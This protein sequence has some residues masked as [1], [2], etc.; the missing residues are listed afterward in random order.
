MKNNKQKWVLAVLVAFEIALFSVT[1]RNFFSITNFFECIRL[2]VEIGLLALALTPVIVTGGIDLSVG[3]MMGLCAVC[4]GALWSDAHWPMPVAV[5]VTLLI[6]LAG[7]AINGLLISRLNVSALVVTLG[8]YSLFRG[9]AEAIT[10]GAKN[11]SGFPASFLFLGQGYLGGVVPAQTV[12][13]VVA[14]IGFWALLHRSVVGRGWYAIGHSAVAAKYAA[15]PV[16]RRVALA[17]VLSGFSAGMAA[18]IYI[19][20]LGQAR[21]DAGTGYEL[22]AITA[23]ILGGA[24]ILG[25]SGTITGTLLGLAA[26]VI[27]QNGLRLSAW[28]TELAG[29]LTGVLLI[30]TIALEQITNRRTGSEGEGTGSLSTHRKRWTVALAG[31]VLAVF[32]IF[33]GHNGAAGG[34]RITIGVMPKA[35]GDPYFI[36]CRKGAEEAARDLNIDLI[37]DGP[38]AL[39]AA[40]QNAVVQGWI[41]RH[42]DAISVAVENG[43]GIST[44]LRKA[45][46]QGIEVTTWDA[47]ALRDARDYFI[48]PATPQAIGYTL[49]YEAARLMNKRGEFAI[50]TGALSAANQNEWIKFM[51]ERAARQYPGMKL[52]TIRPS[53]DDH[54]KAFAETQTLLQVYPNLKVIIGISAPAVPG[55]GEAVKQSGRRDV[56]VIGLSLPNLCKPYVHDG[57]I[58]AVVLWNT[59]NLGYLA[60]AVPA[61]LA[62]GTQLKGQVNFDGGRVGRVGI[63]GRQVVLGQP[64]IFRKDNID[65][66]GF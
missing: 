56:Q 29:I 26:I 36:S 16:A 61:A 40:A 55:A 15:I 57:F 35:K 63:E 30:L 34:K 45:R 23:V 53:D 49:F 27:L 25:G 14:G 32:A 17:Y 12:F 47:D 19:A 22:I 18:I 52:L 62:R 31:V 6:S 38:T 28:P 64:V 66:F 58:E 39:D 59:K 20:H 37:W 21:S 5:A 42:V 8:T 1:G 43:P 3:S 2:A 24:S 4:F 9:L 54:D 65:Q 60:V 41:T 48:N 33:A 44:V 7:G 13:L 11:Y 51:R 10:T 46:A 50:I